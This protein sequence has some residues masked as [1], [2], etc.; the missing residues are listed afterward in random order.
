M[1]FMHINGANIH[2]EELSEKGPPVVL[3]PGAR[4]G[5]EAVRPLGERLSADH[6]VIIYDRRNCGASDVVIAGDDSEQEIW[7]DDLYEILNRLDATPAYIGGGSAGCRVSLMLAV[8]H[9]EV[10]LGL[11]LWWVT[12]GAPA[13]GILSHQYYGQFIDEARKGGMDAVLRTPFFAERIAENPSNMDRLGSMKPREFIDVMTRWR[14]FF[15]GDDPVIG[16]TEQELRAIEAPAVIICGDDEVHPRP[17]AEN[18]HR[19]MRP[20]EIHPPLWTG[21]QVA[22]MMHGPTS[23]TRDVQGEMLAAIFLPFLERQ[24]VP[25]LPLG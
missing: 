14:E 24:P 10:V 25:S 21:E 19:L 23:Q 22:R 13:A 18:L 16:A 4:I 8:R 17:V 11:L 9:P 6:R 1:S 3:T 15:T 2:Y 20:S 7:A 12:G 5:M